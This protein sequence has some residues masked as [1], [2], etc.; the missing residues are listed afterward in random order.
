MSIDMD[1]EQAFI[2]LGYSAVLLASLYLFFAGSKLLGAM[3]SVAVI[4]QIQ[5]VFF[6]QYIGLPENS[7]E[8]WATAQS[9]YDCLP[10]ANRLSMHSAQLGQ[11]IFAAAIVMVARSK[12]AANANT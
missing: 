6:S 7:G 9:F 11:F 4:L 2:Y 8:C 12:V 1:F 10:F 5:G 3:F